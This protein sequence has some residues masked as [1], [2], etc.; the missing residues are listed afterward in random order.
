MSNETSHGLLIAHATTLTT[1]WNEFRAI[2]Q[3]EK[4][5]GMKIIFNYPLLLQKY[6]EMVGRLNDLSKDPVSRI[7]SYEQSPNIQFNLPK[8]QLPEFNGKISEWK[9]FVA[10][11]DRMVHNNKRIDQGIKIEYLKTCVKGQA[12]KI[13]NHIEPD[14]ENCNICYELLKM[15][16]ENERELLSALIENIMQLP[17]IKYE[18]AE[19]LKTMHDTVYE[20]IM[21]VR[22]L[23]ISTE[24][25]DALVCHM[26]TRKLDST[27]LVHYECQLNDV[28]LT[29][30]IG[31]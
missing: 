20:S 14:P 27:T 9:H 10:L 17:K 25:W 5:A 18:N 31:V 29:R 24:N 16:Y 12:A 4:A 30:Q 22:N 28:P 11:F 15:R 7:Q 23:G 19:M 2:Y 13:I 21:S 1:T 3:Q 26:L 8:I 6:M